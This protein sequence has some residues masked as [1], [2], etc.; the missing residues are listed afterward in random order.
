[1]YLT[2]KTVASPSANT[3]F[4]HL[5]LRMRILLVTSPDRTGDWLAQAFAQDSAVTVVLEEA[6]GI[7]AGLQRLRDELFDAVLVAHEPPQLDALEFMDALRGGGAEEPVIVLGKAS[8]A[9]L[10]PLCFEVGADAY[11]C[12]ETTSTRLLIWHVARACERQALHRENRRL[13][14]AE[15]QRVQHE[16]LE[17]QRLIDEQRALVRDLEALQQSAAETNAHDLGLAQQALNRD[18]GNPPT[19]TFSADLVTHYH[20]LLRAYVM[21]GSGNLAGEI[22]T[23]TDL[24]A[25]GGVSTTE[26]LQLHLE[27]VQEMVRGLGTRSARHVMNRADLLI[28][29]VMVHLG[30]DYRR[31]WIEHHNPLR[32]AA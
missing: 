4:G 29:E 30:E 8:E 19:V 32:H 7:A 2:P 31:R 26:T 21:M 22:G 16:H 10:S 25:R 3:T 18:A 6:V 15:K 24:L 17:A 13:A 14:Q 1:M 28:L 5:P 11:L 20:Q 23:L 9:E 27:V 12:V